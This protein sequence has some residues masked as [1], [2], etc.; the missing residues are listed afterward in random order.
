MMLLHNEISSYCFKASQVQ[1]C[2]SWRLKDVQIILISEA[3]LQK[4]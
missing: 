3:L 1:K 2:I 4:I